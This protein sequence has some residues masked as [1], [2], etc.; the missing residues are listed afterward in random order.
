MTFARTIF[1]FLKIFDFTYYRKF[2]HI[3]NIY[4]ILFE[5]KSIVISKRNVLIYI[6][7]LISRI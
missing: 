5:S 1:K 3:F 7:I 4:V 6:T 2:N